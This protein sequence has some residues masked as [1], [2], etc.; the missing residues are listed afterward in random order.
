MTTVPNVAEVV[1]IP[2]A[3]VLTFVEPAGLM[4][5]IP[6]T[7]QSPADRL[8]LVPFND[9]PE[10]AEVASV[11]AVIYSPTLPALALLLVVVPTMPLVCEGVKLPVED[12][13]VAATGSGVVEP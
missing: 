5:Q 9:V 8:I 3:I 13:V 4:P 11:L 12:S 2:A 7:S 1:L 10:V 6:I